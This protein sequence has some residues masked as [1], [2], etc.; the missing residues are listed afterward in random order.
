MDESAMPN[1]AGWLATQPPKALPA[2]VASDNSYNVWD[3]SEKV[4]NEI[5]LHRR[6]RQHDVE[7][8]MLTEGYPN[9][10]NAN[11]IYNQVGKPTSLE[12]VKTTHCTEKCTWFSDAVV[13]SIHG[14][15]LEQTSTLS[16][17]AYTYDAAGRL[18][19]V[20]NTPAGGK[21]TTRIYEYDADTNRTD[22]K[23]YE[24]GTEGKCATEKGTE[25]KYTYDEADRLIDAGTKYG[26]FGDITS[27]PA[28]DAGGKEAPKD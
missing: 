17:Q 6:R 25:E 18:T 10:M 13:P 7:G 3:E 8:N 22:L 28:A 23:T 2:P 15:W 1:L 9:G 12:Y 24:P 5:R 11:Y 14:Q 4:T 27:L 21:C 26:E 19:Q 16:H 20:Q